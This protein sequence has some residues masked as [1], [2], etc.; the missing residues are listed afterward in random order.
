MT[1]QPYTFTTADIGCHADGTFGIKHLREVLEDLLDGLALSGFPVDP[2]VAQSLL[3]PMPD[4]AWDE[5]EAIEILQDATEPGCG[6]YWTMDSGDLLL[7]Q[8]E[9]A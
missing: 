5:L 4:D 8:E 2:E 6:L 3:G 9:D 7:V 1:D